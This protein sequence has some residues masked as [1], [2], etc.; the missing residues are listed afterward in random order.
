MAGPES[1]LWQRMKDNLAGKWDAQRHED[2]SAIGVPDVSFGARGVQGW[3]ELKSWPEMKCSFNDKVYFKK[4]KKT[5][6]QWLKR[7]HRNG[8]RCFAFIQV[9][10]KYFLFRADQLNDIDGK[11]TGELEEIAYGF[12]SKRVDWTELL[13]LITK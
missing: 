8:K 11:T 7:R 5:Q 12:W 2:K 10:W 4:L 1:K 3:I 13:E 9:G 6:R